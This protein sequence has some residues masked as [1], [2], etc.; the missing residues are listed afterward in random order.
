MVVFHRSACDSTTPSH[1]LNQPQHAPLPLNPVPEAHPQVPP[2]IQDAVSHRTR[3]TFASSLF[4]SLNGADSPSLR[5]IFKAVL[6]IWSQFSEYEFDVILSAFS[7]LQAPSF[8][9]AVAS[10]EIESSAPQGGWGE[11]TLALGFGRGNIEENSGG[12]LYRER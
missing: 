11:L 1:Q 4:S 6:T 10:K 5:T 7:P 12:R 3:P 9:A 2:S 8:R